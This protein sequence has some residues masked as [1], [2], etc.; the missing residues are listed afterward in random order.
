MKIRS[1]L[2]EVEALIA[3]MISIGGEF[4]RNDS[5]WSHMKNKE[6]FHQVHKITDLR[7]KFKIERIYADGRDIA[8]FMSNALQS[9]NYDFSTYPTLNKIIER[10]EG[11]WVYTDF[12]SIIEEAENTADELGYNNWAFSQM[13]SMFKEQVRLL[14]VISQTIEILKQSDL[15]KQENGEQMTKQVSAINITN[16]TN[17]NI[18][19]N[20]DN[21]T[22]NVSVQ[23]EVFKNILDAIES[24]GIAK[25]KELIN[26]TRAMETA[27]EKGS[28]A[29]SY[30]IFM[31]LAADH[32]TVFLPFLPMLAKLL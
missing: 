8:I 23:N 30:K 15:Y 14:Q 24:S 9:I 21:V 2:K 25:K 7:K 27:S 28:I 13:L 16:V 1:D 12:T 3:R 18:S 32:L 6:D 22:Q 31:S 20:S 5:D 11:T 17:S 4:E 29:E 19:L 10:F 26:A